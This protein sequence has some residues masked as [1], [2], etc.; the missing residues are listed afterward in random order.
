MLV[1]TKTLLYS[2]WIG[3]LFTQPLKPSVPS[4]TQILASDGLCPTEY[5]HS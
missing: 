2:V 3:L 1:I 5:Q 4:P